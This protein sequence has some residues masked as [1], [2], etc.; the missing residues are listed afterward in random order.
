MKAIYDNTFCMDSK[1]VNYFED[2]CLLALDEK[3]MDIEPYN[4]EYRESEECKEFVE[5]IC[6]G[7]KY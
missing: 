3:G 7:Y 2:M 5:G 4:D 6:E 1:C